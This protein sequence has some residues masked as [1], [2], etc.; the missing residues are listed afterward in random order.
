MSAN[1]SAYFSTAN[2]TMLHMGKS[3]VTKPIL[4]VFS[5]VADMNAKYALALILTLQG[6]ATNQCNLSNSGTGFS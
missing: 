3:I 4:C 1:L 5:F 6:K 2:V